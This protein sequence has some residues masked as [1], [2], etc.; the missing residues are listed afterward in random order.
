MKYSLPFLLILWASQV[1]TQP[2]G[3]LFSTLISAQWDPPTSGVGINEFDWECP[4]CFNYY[5]TADGPNFDYFV[6]APHDLVELD[7]SGNE[8]CSDPSNCPFSGTQNCNMHSIL[9]LNPPSSRYSS[10][11]GNSSIGNNYVNF[12]SQPTN[13]EWFVPTPP[14][15]CV[16]PGDSTQM[17]INFDQYSLFITQ[18]ITD[19]VCQQQSIQ[20]PTQ[21]IKSTIKISDWTFAIGSTGLRLHYMIAGELQNVIDFT[22]YPELVQVGQPISTI[23]AT[24]PSM[25]SACTGVCHTNFSE[26][27]VVT[28]DRENQVFFPTYARIDGSNVGTPIKISGPYQHPFDLRAR[29]FFLDFP[30]F[31][32]SVEYDI[33]VRIKLAGEP[34]ASPGGTV[35]TLPGVDILIVVGA[36]GG[37]IICCCICCIIYKVRKAVRTVTHKHDK[38]SGN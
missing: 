25:E 15:D 18:P 35:L 14:P 4:F 20:I 36:V 21:T 24:P 34:T 31:N 22:L 11:V 19:V 29:V 7:S 37:F 1:F 8:C 17:C 2:A 23:G 13:N 5:L 30:L 16:V 33:Y 28:T 12:T 6:H 9:F 26:V 3:P 38:H 32:I 27:N 10:S